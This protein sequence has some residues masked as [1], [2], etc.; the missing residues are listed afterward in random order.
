M[1]QP[2][3]GNVTRYGYTLQEFGG[4]NRLVRINENEFSDMENMSSAQYPLLS[5]R[6]KGSSFAKR[7][8]A[9][10]L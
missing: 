5:V 3:R 1:R 6:E 2:Y 8:R 9:Q 7:M 4:I 10:R